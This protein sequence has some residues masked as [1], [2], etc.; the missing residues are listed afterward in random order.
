[1]IKKE[2]KVTKEMEINTAILDKLI[3]LRKKKDETKSKIDEIKYNKFFVEALIKFEY[4][5]HL[6]CNKYKRYSNY[7]DLLQEGRIGLMTALNKFDPN[8]SRNI[9]KLMNWYIKTKIKR[10]ANKYDIINVPMAIAADSALIRTNDLPT[11]TDTSIDAI[12]IL[13]KEQIINNIKEALKHLSDIHKYVVCL[14]YGIDTDGK[15]GNKVSI[16]SIA[17]Q[18]KTTRTNVEKLLSEAY[19]VLLKTETIEILVSER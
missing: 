17:K 14:Y 2:I 9:F 8:R 15:L 4:I 12:D 6:H 19:S 11:I 10:Q 7:Q 16:S 1:M 13:E 18:M 3:E 5:V